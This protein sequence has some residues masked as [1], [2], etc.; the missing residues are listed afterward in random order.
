MKKYDVFAIGNPLMD[1]IIEVDE[2][3]LEDLK[4]KKGNMHLVDSAQKEF[5]KIFLE[6]KIK[7]NQPGG[8]SSNTSAGIANLGGSAFFSGKIGK[9]STGKE[10]ERIM[11]QQGIKCDLKKDDTPTGNV[12][13][14]TT[15]DG[16]RTFATYLGGAIKYT[17]KDLNKKELLKSKIL[18]IEGYMLE[19]PELKKASINAMKIAKKNK[20]I[21]STDL[22]DPS[23][24]QRNIKSFRE[25]VKEYVDILFLN[26]EEAKVFTGIENKEDA[27]LVLSSM[28]NLAI[29]KLG[30]HG[31]IIRIRN[32]NLKFNAVKPK[33]IVNTNG[34]GDM[35]AAGIL[36]SIAKGLSLEEAGKIASITATKVVEQQ[37]A[38]LI[39]K[40]I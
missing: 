32:K 1:T 40:I 15:K 12:I 28:V 3:D 24:I 37:G 2:Q 23:L 16:E 5:I 7:T 29:I 14:L 19:N 34:A 21:V 27:L 22:S 33:K 6:K 36:Y 35:Y 11:L 20:I 30:E 39:N 25:I 31:S 17:K 10:Y 38:R 26:E 18:H 9:D 4:L 8:S 13:V